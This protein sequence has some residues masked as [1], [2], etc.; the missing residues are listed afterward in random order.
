MRWYWS[1][2]SVDWRVWLS[3]WSGDER[4]HG[5][6]RGAG[7]DRAALHLPDEE[8][9]GVGA[10]R[11]LVARRLFGREMQV[12][13]F[14]ERPLGSLGKADG[15]RGGGAV[16][17]LEKQA[18]VGNQH[19][20]EHGFLP[21]RGDHEHLH[22]S[23]LARQGAERGEVLR[24][25]LRLGTHEHC[26][27]L[28]HHLGD[29]LQAREPQAAVLDERL[30]QAGAI[31]AHHEAAAPARPEA[32]GERRREQGHRVDAG[33]PRTR[34]V[35][36]VEPGRDLLRIGERGEQQALVAAL[37]RDRLAERQRR[38][39]ARVAIALR[40]PALHHR[41]AVASAQVRDLIFVEILAGQVGEHRKE[42]AALV[43]QVGAEALHSGVVRGEACLEL[44][45]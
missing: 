35:E 5:E 25:P 20:L 38:R 27:R 2:A 44:E 13:A 18:R 26:E 32:G 28:R 42:R 15:A 11:E 9:A 7:G 21:R 45:R 36:R 12:Q 4:A 41:V 10:A 3:A 29:A 6:D 43:A 17:R 1:A 31:R 30:P 22:R 39:E 14:G 33:E 19:L 37:A 16:D 23:A 40:Q 8:S 24:Q 34:G